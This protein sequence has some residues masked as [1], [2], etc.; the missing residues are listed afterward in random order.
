MFVKRLFIKNFRCFGS[1]PTIVDFSPS[2]LT[3]LIGP[4]NVGKSTALH[5][6]EILL[7]DRWPSG[8][9]SED[10]FHL[11]QLDTPIILACEFTDPLEL[12]IYGRQATVLGV[13]LAATHLDSGYGESSVNTDY[14]LLES[15]TNFEN[16]DWDF[17]SRGPNPTRISQD[18]KNDLPV[19]VT[20]PLIKLSREQP[21]NKWGVLGRMLQKVERRFTATPKSEADFTAKIGEAVSILR[22]QKD[23]KDIERDIQEL[24]EDMRPVN[25]GDTSLQFLDHEPWRY[26]RQFKLAIRKGE[27][28]VPIDTLGE[29]VQRL[30][31]IALY[32]T[33]LR[34]HGRNHRAILLIEEPESYLHPQARKTLFRVLR[35]AIKEETD[36]EGQVIYT[37]HSEDFIDCGDFEDIAVFANTEQGVDVR[38]LNRG[39]MLQHIQALKRFTV[40]V[41]EPGIHYRLMETVTQGLKEALFAHKVVIVEGPSELELFSA[42]S[43]ADTEQVAIVVADGKANIPSIYAF[44]TAFGIPCLVTIDRD[45]KRIGENQE[46]ADCLRQAFASSTDAT[47]FEV[48]EEEIDAV[49]DGG[50]WTKDRLMVFGKNL[51]SVLSKQ[52][53]D[54]A[55]AIQTL[56]KATG[57]PAS[58]TPRVIRALGLA[59]HG[60]LKDTEV[61]AMIA[62]EK[63][64]IDR[65]RVQLNAFVKQDV[66][67][68]EVLSMTSSADFD[69]VPF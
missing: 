23:F 60:S 63:D 11:N 57:L 46:V 64:R 35:S 48:S 43:D 13:Y 53:R 3:A 49:A 16:A 18:T 19:V 50:K 2:G 24:W 22:E 39:K 51:E 17:V 29:G 37:T 36:I 62:S 58:S 27:Q 52:L 54:F 32:R 33:Y 66:G 28:D 6:L 38:R 61:T 21:T 45:E 12:D 44:L 69:E 1:R 30:A 8:H 68:P 7:G 65:I 40:P 55:G 67:R 10:D 4:N 56:R 14:F 9:F 41:S 26:Y 34:R 47:R 5:A 59:Y 25:L 15:I 20:V 31:V 42:F